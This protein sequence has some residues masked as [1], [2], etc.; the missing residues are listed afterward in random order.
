MSKGEKFKV[1]IPGSE[2]EADGLIQKIAE[3]QV[4]Q[5]KVDQDYNEEIARLKNKAKGEIADIQEEMKGHLISLLG[6]YRMNWK[7]LTE[8]GKKKI[9]ELASGQIGSYETTSSV[10]IRN[11]EKVI[12]A[13]KEHNLN[14]FIRTEVIEEINKEAIRSDP[15]SVSDIEGIRIIKKEKFMVKP[16]KTGIA[17]SDE[18]KKLK[19]FLP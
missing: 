9:I 2:D 3:L 1:I 18:I 10:N 16:L 4:E 7:E 13:L 17:V 12:K 14:Q 15:N 6:F 5:E 8:D 11:I 19:K